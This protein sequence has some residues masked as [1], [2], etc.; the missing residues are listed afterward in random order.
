M[1]TPLRDSL[2]F[3]DPGELIASIPGMLSFLPEDS[4]VL[5]T[6]TGRIR[7]TME[8]V[9]RLD[10]PDPK[11]HADLAEQLRVVALNHEATVIELVVLGD[12]PDSPERPELP[13]RDL[14]DL[15]DQVL[16]EEGITLAH[17]VWAPRV[18]QGRT[19]WCYDDPGCTGPI[20]DPAASPITTTMTAAG[21]VTYP[22][23][24]ELAAQL[25]PDPPDTLARRAELLAAQPPADPEAAFPFVRDTIDAAPAELDDDTVARL[26]RALSHP[27]V[28]EACL[29]FA[30]TVR[31]GPAERLWL[32]LTRATPGP[33]RADPASLLA[34]TA[35]LRGEGAMATLAV[36]AALTANPDHHLA[37]TVRHVMDYGFPPDRFRLMLAQSFVTAFAGK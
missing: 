11:H 24:A 1:T 10:L 3:D 32:T 13:R 25:A 21:V 19:W 33:A 20:R 23:R 29:S 18:E 36:D 35:F 6:Y 30:L 8:S 28:R 12:A 14:V 2:L 17:A 5:V 31:A 4:L 7:L 9:L 37:R 27:D 16:A 26:A 34:V 15:L 22:T